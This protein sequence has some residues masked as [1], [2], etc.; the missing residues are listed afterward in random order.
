[1]IKYTPSNQLTLEGF[2]HPFEQELCPKNRWIK[3]ASII[4]WDDLVC[5]YSKSLNSNYGRY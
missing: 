3:L 4:P 1:M 2:L 5:V